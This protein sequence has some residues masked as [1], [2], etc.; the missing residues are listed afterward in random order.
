[1]DRNPAVNMYTAVRHACM[2]VNAERE[3][4]GTLEDLMSGRREGI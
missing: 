3:V 1:M 4:Q 2:L